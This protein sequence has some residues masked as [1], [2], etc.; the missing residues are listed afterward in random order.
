MI[1]VLYPNQEKDVQLFD[2]Y[3]S[4]FESSEKRICNTSGTRIRFSAFLGFQ[5][6]D[7]DP[8]KSG[9]VTSLVHCSYR[10]WLQHSCHFFQNADFWYKA[11]DG[12]VTRQEWIDKLHGGGYRSGVDY[13]ISMFYRW[14]RHHF[15]VKCLWCNPKETYRDG[16]KDWS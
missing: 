5:G 16:N 13:P 11:M 7:S 15:C 2:D 8:V 3:G 10:L 12:K 9:I 1:P 4:R 6:T 14:M